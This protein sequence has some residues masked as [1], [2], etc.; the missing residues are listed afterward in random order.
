MF[1]ETSKIEINSLQLKDRKLSDQIQSA[2]STE[3]ES[4]HDLSEEE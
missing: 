2:A 4:P 3:T 1:V